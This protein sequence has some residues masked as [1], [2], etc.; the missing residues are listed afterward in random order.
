MTKKYF[1]FP[2]LSFFSSLSRS[3]V[4]LLII[5][6]AMNGNVSFHDALTT[7]LNTIQPSKQDVKSFLSAHPFE[8]T[9]GIEKLISLLHCQGKIVYLL[10]GGFRQMIEPVAIKLKIPSYRVYANNLLFQNDEA[11]SFK[12]FD[13]SEPTSRDGGKGAVL[14]ML[15]ANHGYRNVVMVGDG[16]TDLQ[17]KP[18]AHLFIGFGGVIVRPVVEE[19]ADLFI[20]DFNDIIRILN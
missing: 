13:P 18:P 1:H 4:S 2:S 9:D 12:G 14:Q 8:L 10:S 19:K 6:R 20:K 17:A 11:G 3:R 5:C 16:V 7:R 15:I